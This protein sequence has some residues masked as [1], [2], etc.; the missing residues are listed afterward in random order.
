MARRPDRLKHL[1]YQRGRGPE[2]FELSL[3]HME[4]ADG[5]AAPDSLPCQIQRPPLDESDG[6]ADGM[7]L[8]STVRN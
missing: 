4:L 5:T 6:A 7:T 3:R 2:L 1:V 8:L